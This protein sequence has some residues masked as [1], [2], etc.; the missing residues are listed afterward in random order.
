MSLYRLNQESTSKEVGAN[1]EECTVQAVEPGVCG[2][3]RSISYRAGLSFGSGSFSYKGQPEYSPF[4]G[5]EFWNLTEIQQVP[6]VAR[7]APDMFG[8]IRLE[9]GEVAYAG[10]LVLDRISKRRSVRMIVRNLPPLAVPF[11]EAAHPGSAGRMG[12]KTWV[13]PVFLAGKLLESRFL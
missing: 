3:G 1:G 9:P 11:L 7:H 13:G 2:L 12:S 5:R 10:E 4:F 8:I 6:L